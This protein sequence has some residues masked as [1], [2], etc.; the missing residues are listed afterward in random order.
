MLPFFEDHKNL[1]LQTLLCVSLTL[2]LTFLKIPVLFLH[3]LFTYIHP[4]NVGQGNSGSSSG[5]RAAIRRPS[6]SD[7]GP[8]L[9]GYQSLSS[10]TN[11]ELK[12]RNKSKDKKFEFDESNAQIFRLKL[13]E[14]HLQT[15]LF[16]ND[17]HNSFLFSFVGISCLLLYMYLGASEGSGNGNFIPLILGFIGLTK[18]FLALAKISFERSASKRSEKQFSAIF[19]VLGFV[20]GIMICSGIGPSVFDFHFDSIEGSWRILIAIFMGLIA[21]FLYM[22]A[23]KNARS[24]W[25]GTDQLRCNLSIISCGWFARMILYANYMLTVFTALL[26]INPFAEIFV[27]KNSFHGGS[28][29]EK[30]VGNVG[31]PESEF[32]RFRL[33][34]LLLSGIAQIVV[35]RSNLQM[36]LNEAVL[37][38]YQR[39]HAS[40]VPDLDFSRAKVFL[41]NHYLCL[42]ALQFFAPS[43]LVLLFLGLSQIDTNSFDKYNLVC[44]LLPCS[45]FVKEVAVFMAWWIVFVWSVITSA[46]LV[47]YRRG[48]LYV[49]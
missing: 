26:W 47:F 42:A 8:G 24:F 30:L 11:A 14:G 4:E 44:G 46:S 43:V 23:G 12:K 2:I 19:G 41:H 5:V 17:Y 34:C 48:V 29:A 27:N 13:D 38:W 35:V 16:F 7:S 3:G 49:F 37:S 36:F 45:A 1:I 31:F 10:R 21:G 9:D 39:L 25:L 6:G 32:N 40:K 28:A 20:I 15:R 33:L 18:S 22:P